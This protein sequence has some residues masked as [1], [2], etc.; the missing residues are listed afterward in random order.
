MEDAFEAMVSSMYI[1]A[2]QFHRGMAD[3]QKIDDL[4]GICVP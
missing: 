1:A 3:F 4:H 2:E